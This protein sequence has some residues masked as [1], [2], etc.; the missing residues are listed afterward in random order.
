MVKY[1]SPRSK[2]AKYITTCTNCNRTIMKFPGNGK[3]EAGGIW[4]HPVITLDS[5]TQTVDVT[6]CMRTCIR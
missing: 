6:G 5:F 2:K 4:A 1:A 3:A